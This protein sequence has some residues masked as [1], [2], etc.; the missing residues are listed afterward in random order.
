MQK[1]VLSWSVASPTD[2]HIEECYSAIRERKNFGAG[3]IV[4]R[5]G[6]A[7]KIYGGSRSFYCY[8]SAPG[9]IPLYYLHREGEIHV[10]QSYLSMKRFAKANGFKIKDIVQCKEGIG[11]HLSAKGLRRYV[12]DVI[13][14]VSG[15]EKASMDE[16]ANELLKR[17]VDAAMF[18]KIETE[19]P[20]V[21]T[22]SGGSDGLLTALALKLAGVKQ[23]CVCVGRSED[24]FDPSYARKYAEQL[25]LDYRFLPLPSDDEGLSALLRATLERIEMTDYSNVLMGM[26]NMV[27]AQF[28]ESIGAEWVAAADL[29][30]V[31]LGNDIMTTGKFLKEVAEPTALKWARY[32]M[33]H[34][35]YT[36][37]NNLM[38]YKVFDP[39]RTSDLFV[40]RDVLEFLLGLSLEVTPPETRKP[41]YYHLLDRYVT[42]GS[43]HDQKKKVGFYTGAGIGKIRLENPIL[44]DEN[45][46]AVM[47][48]I[49]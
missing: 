46:R 19:R 2:F 31:V 17:L 3:L 12:L 4:P 42:G 35:L 49:E 18:L 23:V 36:L 9:M 6:V 47:A 40:N 21:T 33:D 8:Q 38:V 11:Y 24:D 37:P 45:I 28:A 15:W 41:L 44:Q 20:V 48:T 39:L 10:S 29:A 27:V 1:D 30:D 5:G 13:G 25:G 22:I 32:R 34:Q 14:R 16:C 7:M 26:C 43:W